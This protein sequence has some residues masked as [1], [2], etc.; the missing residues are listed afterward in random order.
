MPQSID[1]DIRNDL[2]ELQRVMESVEHLS[3]EQSWEPGLGM[4]IQLILEELITN[5]ISYGY[6]DS[7]RH[8]IMIRLHS[9]SESVRIRIEDDAGPFDP[10]EME[11][12]DLSVPVQ[13]RE[14]GGLGVHLVR[15]LADDIGYTRQ[16]GKNILTLCK[17]REPSK[18]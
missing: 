7:E 13:E 2:T 9:D 14:P 1:I 16:D 4:R 5:I 11:T 12:P 8:E 17:N 15:N 10:L 3:E 6:A 18:G